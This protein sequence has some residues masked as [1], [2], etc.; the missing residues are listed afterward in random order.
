MQ[1]VSFQAVGGGDLEQ[2]RIPGSRA[3]GAGEDHG[4]PGML[5]QGP[6]EG[7][8]QAV[9]GTVPLHFVDG[10]A[11]VGAAERVLAVGDTVWP[12]GRDDAPV[13]RNGSAF[14]ERDDQVPFPVAQLPQGSPAGSNG[15]GVLP[16]TDPVL[17]H[18]PPASL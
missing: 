16:R 11:V 15:G 13:V 9:Q 10:H 8:D 5:L 1:A 7:E 17:G 14:R 6:V 4:G 12:G 2:E 18:S 3:N